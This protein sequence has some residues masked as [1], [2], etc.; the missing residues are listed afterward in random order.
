MEK[1]FC[2][3]SDIVR[4]YNNQ[5]RFGLYEV[6][7]SFV[8]INNAP[9]KFNY[10]MNLSDED[11]KNEFFNRLKNFAKMIRG[12]EYEIDNLTEEQLT[13]IKN[14][15]IKDYKKL[16]EQANRNRYAEYFRDLIN[17][18]ESL[19]S[20]IIREKIKSEIYLTELLEKLEYISSE[21]IEY[22]EHNNQAISAIFDNISNLSIFRNRINSSSDAYLGYNI[23]LY[24][25]ISFPGT[26]SPMFKAPCTRDFFNILDNMMIFYK[27][28]NIKYSQ[29]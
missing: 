6:Y 2:L 12:L 9:E 4:N 29:N 1:N 23:P 22:V 19:S 17:Y 26:E 28:N 20:E 8:L 5:T 24:G 11:Y 18:I 27:E 3:F 16:E 21:E 25:K 15:T 10:N 13:D 14:A 7:K